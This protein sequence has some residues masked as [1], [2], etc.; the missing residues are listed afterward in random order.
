MMI[1]VDN[2]KWSSTAT[3]KQT[4]DWKNKPFLVKMKFYSLVYYS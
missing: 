4:Q 1:V 3:R 2:E